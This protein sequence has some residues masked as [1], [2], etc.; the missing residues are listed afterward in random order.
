MGSA[1]YLSNERCRT[2]KTFPSMYRDSIDPVR[3]I[4]SGRSIGRTIEL[5]W[6]QA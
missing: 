5:L 2:Y 6:C 1:S 4:G 3:M